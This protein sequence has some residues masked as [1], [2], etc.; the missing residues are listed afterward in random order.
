MI[1][2]NRLV[3]E[4]VAHD[5]A[6]KLE[7]SACDLARVAGQLAP[8]QDNELRHIVARVRA[9]AAAAK[10]RPVPQRVEVP[11]DVRDF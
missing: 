9:I 10:P 8:D 7:K 3:G 2:H 4:A 11:G 5:A 6:L 1:D